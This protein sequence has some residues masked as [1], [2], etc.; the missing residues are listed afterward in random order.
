MKKKSGIT[1]VLFGVIGRI[2]DVF[3]PVRQNEWVFGAACGNAYREGSK[4]LF[5]YMLEKHPEYKVTFVT[6]SKTVCDDLRARHLPCVHNLS[7]S[8]I[9]AIA[10]AGCVFSTNIASDVFFAHKKKGRRFFYL[11]H[12]QPYKVAQLALAKTGYQKR[13]IGENNASVFAQ[14]LGKAKEILHKW[15][16][17]D[18]G[19]S[20]SEFVSAT[21]EFLQKWMDKDFDGNTPVKVLGM[22]RNDA[23]FQPERMR[24]ER[25]IDGTEGKFVVSYMPTHRLYGRGNFSPAPFASRPDVQQW[26]KDNDVV[27]VVKNHPTMLLYQGYTPV[28]T[29]CIKDITDRGI[30]PMTAVFRSDVLITDYS[31]VWMDYLLMRRPI[32]FY[33]YDDFEHDDAGVYYDVKNENVGHFCYNEDELFELLKLIKAKYDEM[34]PGGDV[35]RKFHKYVDGNSC[36]RYFK[37]IS[38]HG[39]CAEGHKAE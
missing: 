22:P 10:R 36:E 27:L 32:I 12:G 3:V 24:G 11:V 5:E 29:E 30:D 6:R 17:C 31:S 33:I 28:E 39:L 38:A 34:R 26:M 23:L 15:L 18:H 9:M 25:W 20:C 16:I 7:A 8:G 37:Y 35:V 14:L 4:Y 13:L 19:N 2:V 1:D 21:S